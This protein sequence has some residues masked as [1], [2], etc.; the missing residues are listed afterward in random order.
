MK[1][2]NPNTK[3][4]KIILIIVMVF[5]I[6]FGVLQI[7]LGIATQRRMK[8]KLDSYETVKAKIID[9]RVKNVRANGSKGNTTTKHYYPIY[10]YKVNGKEYVYESKLGVPS[11]KSGTEII[12]Y[13]P[14][15]PSKVVTVEEKGAG[16]IFILGGCMCISVGSI[17]ILVGTIIFKKR[18]DKKEQI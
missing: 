5:M 4:K 7:I 11:E 6:I 3:T 13:N 1:I 10:S 9:C 17:V 16:V 8:D 2:I 15:N 14:D 18:K 12:Y